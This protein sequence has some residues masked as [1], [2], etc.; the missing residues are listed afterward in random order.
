MM[1]LENPT[2]EKLR[3]GD[4]IGPFEV[5]GLD[6]SDAVWSVKVATDDGLCWLP[7]FI[8]RPLIEIFGIERE[9]KW[10][11]TGAIIERSVVQEGNTINLVYVGPKGPGVYRYI[12]ERLVSE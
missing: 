12:E 11:P 7:K 4:K 2:I 6:S 5:S 1:K 10:E 9:E 8:T 3:V